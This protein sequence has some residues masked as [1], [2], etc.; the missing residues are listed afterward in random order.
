L[1]D[2]EAVN[3]IR[4]CLGEGLHGRSGPSYSF[5]PFVS[6]TFIQAVNNYISLTKKP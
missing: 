5:L 3:A 6:I 2:D 1:A 4:F